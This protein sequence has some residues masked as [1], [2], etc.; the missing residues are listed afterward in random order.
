MGLDMYLNAEYFI[1]D[2]GEAET[3]ASVLRD[4][5]HG[6]IGDTPGNVQTICTEAAYWRKANQIHKWFVDNVQDGKDE[7]QRAYVDR[8]QLHTLVELCQKVLDKP[9]SAEEMLPTEGGFFFGD[10]EYGEDYMEDLKRT[11]EMLTEVLDE[12]KYPSKDWDFH[13][14]SSW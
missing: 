3:K 5:I 7:C 8:T 11:V 10:T 12:E 2:Y 6:V 13:Y 4:A 1:W 9:D 14:R